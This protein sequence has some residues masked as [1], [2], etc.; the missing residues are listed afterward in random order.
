VGV[1]RL[2]EVNKQSLEDVVV[3]EGKDLSI[4]Y[5]FGEFYAWPAVVLT[6]SGSSIQISSLPHFVL[7][8]IWPGGLT[9]GGPCAS[10][11]H[12]LCIVAL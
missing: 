4:P 5:Y 3:A 7:Q 1:T 8:F 12:K 10:S 11:S 6:L 2:P 9:R